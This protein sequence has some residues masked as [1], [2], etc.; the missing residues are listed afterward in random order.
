MTLYNKK[1]QRKYLNRSER[2]RFL[3]MT[4]NRPVETKL[5][6]QLL[7]YTGARL[8]EIYNLTTDSIDFSNET[9][10]IETLKKRQRGVFRE[11]PLPIHLLYELEKYIGA[12]NGRKA[13]WLF[14]I[15]TASRRVKAIM[16]DAGITGNRCCSRGLRHGFAV[17]A[18]D[19]APLTLVKKWLG[20]SS[21]ET[22]EIYLNVIGLEE[23]AIAKKVWRI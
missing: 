12:L 13:L 11:I 14:S 5:F 23:R 4:R 21:L 19:K 9:V 17:H 22:T 7:F 10:V 16:M 15:R 6:C 2:Q 20:H 8:S 3:E 1:G 18:V